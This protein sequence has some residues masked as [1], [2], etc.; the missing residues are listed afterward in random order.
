MNW[1]APED[2]RCPYEGCRDTVL[3]SICCPDWWL[4][5]LL[6]RETSGSWVLGGKCPCSTSLDN[7]RDKSKTA[8]MALCLLTVQVS[9]FRMTASFDLALMESE[10]LD[11]NGVCISSLSKAG[12]KKWN[13][14]FLFVFSTFQCQSKDWSKSIVLLHK[15]LL[16]FQAAQPHSACCIEGYFGSIIHLCHGMRGLCLLWEHL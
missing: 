1:E 10:S 3:W 8:C 5:V 12:V 9:I 15:L 14:H 7:P 2:S 6:S 4:H 11:G 16:K 13:F